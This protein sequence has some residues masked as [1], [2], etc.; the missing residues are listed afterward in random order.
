MRLSA[1]AL[2]GAALGLALVS[3]T[4]PVVAQ[5]KTAPPAQAAQS[6][7]STEIVV[8][9]ATN[10]GTGIDAKIGPMPELA[11][12]PFSAYNSYKLLERTRLSVTKSNPTTLKLPNQSVLRLSLKEVVASKK[13]DEPQ[14]YVLSASIQ[15]PGGDSFLP[16]LEVNAKAGENFFVAGQK[17]QGGILVIG[18]KVVP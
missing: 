11:K 15:Q 9:H 2:I 18:F 3:G 8:L 14:R 4:L 6:A 13:K 5:E 1:S 12:P 10:D 16:L 17:H 7:I